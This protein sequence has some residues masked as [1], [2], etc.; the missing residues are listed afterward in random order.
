MRVSLGNVFKIFGSL[1]SI[2]L[3]AYITAQ[4]SD[5]SDKH[6]GLDTTIVVT[7]ALIMLLLFTGDSL[8]KGRIGKKG[9]TYLLLAWLILLVTST[10]CL[11]LRFDL[12]KDDKWFL[13]FLTG[14]LVLMLISNLAFAPKGKAKENPATTPQ[15]ETEARLRAEAKELEKEDLEKKVDAIEA[16]TGSMSKRDMKNLL[17]YKLQLARG[18]PEEYSSPS[19]VASPS[20]SKSPQQGDVINRA[21]M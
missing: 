7:Q 11:L 9:P 1:F 14:N 12:E 5:N 19:P 3:I 4:D 13:A 10:I 8:P 17:D 16:R 20:P 18:W 21:D 2:V 15:D 6:K